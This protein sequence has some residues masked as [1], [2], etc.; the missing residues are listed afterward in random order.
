MRELSS[1]ML[2]GGEWPQRAD[3]VEKHPFADA[4]YRLLNVARVPFLS[5]FSGLLRCRED[6]GQLAE[7]LGGCS[8][9]EFIIC[10]ARPT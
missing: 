4:E 8:E 5:G 2:Q 3:S 9:E 1:K 7:V 10:A 6:L